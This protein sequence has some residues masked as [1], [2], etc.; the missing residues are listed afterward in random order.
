MTS[1]RSVY[2]RLLWLYPASFRREYGEAMVQVFCDRLR[3]EP[4][5]RTWRRT[6]GDLA[7]SVPKQRIEVFTSEQQQSTLSW[8]AVIAAV[9]LPFAALSTV[10]IPAIALLAA[11]AAW[12]AN[13]Q[14]RGRLLR[15]PGQRTWYRWVVSGGVILAIVLATVG[16]SNYDAG[17]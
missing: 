12:L 17:S 1:H 3:D 2:G 14:R 5:V 8:I 4:T 7:R 9:A 6:L 13:Q 11:V 16:F 15:L 10:G